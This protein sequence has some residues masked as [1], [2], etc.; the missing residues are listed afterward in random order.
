MRKLLCLGLVCAMAFAA[1]NRGQQTAAKPSGGE[2]L[3]KVGD[4]L[5]TEEELMRELNALPPQTQMLVLSQGGLRG[6]VEEVVKKELFYIEA[7]K[8]RVDETPEYKEKLKDAQKILMIEALFN[9]E[10]DRKAVV[11]EA[12]IQKYYDENKAEFVPLSKE[13]GK[14]KDEKPLE[15]SLVKDYI[16]QRLKNEKQRTIFEAYIAKLRA[17]N[18]IEINEES[19]QKLEAKSSGAEMMPMHGEPAK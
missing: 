9:R 19:V 4:V 11:A 14:G 7:K 6:V 15:L 3:A 16:E 1:C 8:Q 2:Y 5:I 17:D 10:V 18:K 12:E 13:G